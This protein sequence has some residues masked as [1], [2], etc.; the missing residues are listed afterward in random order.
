MPTKPSAPKGLIGT[1]QPGGITLTWTDTSSNETGFSI[2]R[3]PDG[4]VFSQIATV[5]QN[6]STYLDT[7]PGASIYVFYRVRAFNPAGYSGY[8]N[9]LKVLNQ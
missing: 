6:V 4:H 8:S 7:S 5:A 2:E 9:K 3:S 1:R